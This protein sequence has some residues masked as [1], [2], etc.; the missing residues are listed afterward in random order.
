MRGLTLSANEQ[1]RLQ[2]MNGLLSGQWCI[3]EAAQVM[4][5]SE[6]HGWRLLSAYRKDGAADVDKTQ[7]TLEG[8]GRIE[9]VDH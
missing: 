7:N 8:M 2:I 4:G 3:R 6:R 1:N 9:E 5:V